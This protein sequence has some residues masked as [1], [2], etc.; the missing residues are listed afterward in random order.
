[1]F[2]ARPGATTP[3]EEM[4]PT[5]YVWTSVGTTFIALVTACALVF[6]VGVKAMTLILLVTG[7]IDAFQYTCLRNRAIY[8]AREATT[9]RP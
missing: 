1:M 2:I 4:R 7:T 8:T 6:N 9:R 3:L 5:S